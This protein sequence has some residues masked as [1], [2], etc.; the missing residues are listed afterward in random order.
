[1]SKSEKPLDDQGPKERDAQQ[2]EPISC[3][4]GLL[5]QAYYGFTSNFF[6]RWA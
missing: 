3:P 2:P 4:G 5:P 1:M 6:T